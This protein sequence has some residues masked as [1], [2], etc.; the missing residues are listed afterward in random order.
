ME[1]KKTDPA[2]TWVYLF[3]EAPNPEGLFAVNVETNEFSPWFIEGDLIVVNSAIGKVGS[4]WVLLK[5]AGHI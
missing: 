3:Y 2:Q 1:P 4:G 5:K